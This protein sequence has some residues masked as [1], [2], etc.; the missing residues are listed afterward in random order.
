[1]V[2]VLKQ[3]QLHFHF[4][5]L[6]V[7]QIYLTSL[8]WR[9]VT[10]MNQLLNRFYVYDTLFRAKKKNVAGYNSTAFIELKCSVV[11][12]SLLSPQY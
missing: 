10:E 4:F 8:T 1:M 9:P 2:N 3:I 6:C 7:I 12:H 5:L 11:R